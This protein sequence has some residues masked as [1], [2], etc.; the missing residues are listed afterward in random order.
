MKIAQI[1]GT[2]RVVTHLTDALVSLGHDVTLFA[3]KPGVAAHLAMLHEVRGCAEQFDILH[4]HV[5]L[6]HF[7]MFSS[8]AAQT[9][10]TLHHRL[11]VA[12]LV[13]AYQ[14]WPEYGLVSVSN[15]QRKPLPGA[16]W[17]ATVHHGVPSS[18]YRPQYQRRG[19]YFAVAATDRAY[20]ETCI[21]PLLNHPLVE[22]LGEGDDAGRS[23]LLGDALAL[24]APIDEPEPF[25]LVMIEALA[26]GT[27]V[28]AWDSGPVRELIDDG[29]TGFIVGTAQQA[30]IALERCESLD[31]RHIRAIF[32]QRFSAH[33][34][35]KSYVNI[36]TKLVER[37]RNHLA[38][39]HV[40]RDIIH[41]RGDSYEQRHDARASQTA[42]GQ[43]E[44]AVGQA[45]G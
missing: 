16:H 7:P 24:V 11:D 34:M 40:D 5:D 33:A 6:L 44:G 28:V 38:R 21:A 13:A 4:F 36:Y 35:A 17:L 10:T 2:E 27:P 12:D 45:H 14:C 15:A 37:R 25:G 22:Y 43:T 42:Q 32:Q 39:P 23:Q 41:G 19:S 9:V 18:S 26:C 8:Y 30:R 31:R 29:V 20:F 1:A 3:L